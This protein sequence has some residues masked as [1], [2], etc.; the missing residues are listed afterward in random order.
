MCTVTFWPKK[1]G[2]ILGMNRDEQRSRVAALGPSTV[3]VDGLRV[4]HPS[5]PS[6]GTWIS[7][8]ERGLTVALI[9]WYSVTARVAKHALS[10]GAV[11]LAVRSACSTDEIAACLAAL[12]LERINPFR[13]IAV[14][15]D[16]QRIHEWRWNR[17]TLSAVRH[18]WLPGIWISSGFDEP[19]AQRARSAVFA[20]S[21]RDT[22]AGSV[23]WL[24]RLHCSHR[25]ECGPLSIC[26]HRADAV[27]VSYTEIEAAE[28]ILTM[29]QVMDSPCESHP[30]PQGGTFGLGTGPTD[31]RQ[32]A[33]IDHALQ[34]VRSADSGHVEIEPEAGRRARRAW[35]P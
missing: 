8:N 21:I 6:G 33:I 1:R 13:L 18:P 7:S 9:N 12:P 2:Y 23:A 25:P 34:V 16:E 11:V 15:K 19:G 5:E 17:E 31:R 20:E 27:T 26:M 14:V 4:V 29:R 32:P 22:D 24:R 10:R 3:E 28:G 35:R 30:P